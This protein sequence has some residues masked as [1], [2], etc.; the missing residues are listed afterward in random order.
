MTKA[1]FG[2]STK[3]NAPHYATFSILPHHQFLEKWH[4]VN[5]T[6]QVSHPY[7]ATGKVSFLSP[8][9]DKSAYF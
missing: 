9:T 3:H 7:K 4:S 8:T 6:D 2:S 5:V 1:V